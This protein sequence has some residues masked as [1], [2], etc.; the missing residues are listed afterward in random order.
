LAQVFMT[1]IMCIYIYTCMCS[2]P[3]QN[4]YLCIVR[5]IAIFRKKCIRFGIFK[6]LNTQA[7][8]TMLQ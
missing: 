5:K 7:E 4:R 2:L 3:I 1:L 6:D 8:D